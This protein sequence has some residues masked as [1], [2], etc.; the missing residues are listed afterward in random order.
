[1]S[2]QELKIFYMFKKAVENLKKNP[3]DTRAFDE[4]DLVFGSYRHRRWLAHRSRS[5]IGV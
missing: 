2:P 3:A 4:A 1:M 5:V